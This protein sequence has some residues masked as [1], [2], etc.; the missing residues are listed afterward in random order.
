[1][2][3]RAQILTDESQQPLRWFWLSFAEGRFL[4][5]AIVQAQGAMHAIEKAHRLGI[6]PGGEVASWELPPD[7]TIPDEAQ[8]RLLGRDE[9]E[10]IFGELKQP[11]KED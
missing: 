9:L 1:M 4:G 5:A 11:F 8:D 2:A 10:K 3:R 7:V 6:N